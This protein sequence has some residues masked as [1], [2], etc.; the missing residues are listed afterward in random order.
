[1]IHH[2]Q[3][4]SRVDAEKFVRGE[5]PL[6]RELTRCFD[7]RIAWVGVSNDGS[8]PVTRYRGPHIVEAFADVNPGKYAGIEFE[9]PMR[10]DQAERIVAFVE[11]IAKHPE[12]WAL[13]VHCEAGVSRSGAIAQWVHERHADME[14]SLFDRLH[15]HCLPS[16]LPR[17]PARGRTP[18]ARGCPRRRARRQRGALRDRAADRRPRRVAPIARRTRVL[19]APDRSPY[20]CGDTDIATPIGPPRAGG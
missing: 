10:P 2:V 4:L 6:S 18:H 11:R 12:A 1:M 15:R 9:N 13:M 8:S 20:R 14:R 17:G 16:R 19:A 3:A 5:H 7:N